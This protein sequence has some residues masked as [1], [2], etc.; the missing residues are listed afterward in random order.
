MKN[1][2]CNTRCHSVKSAYQNVR[3]VLQTLRALKLNDDATADVL[4]AKMTEFKFVG[5]L[6]ILSHVLTIL[7]SS[8]QGILKRQNQL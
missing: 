5:A 1:K 8:K 2:V 7:A 3:A 6:A 4:L